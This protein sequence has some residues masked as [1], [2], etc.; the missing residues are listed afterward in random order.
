M[1]VKDVMQKDIIK[2]KKGTPLYQIIELF[3][4]FH[5][6]TLWVVDEEDKLLGIINLNDI[7][8]IFQPTIDK[9]VQDLLKTIRFIDNL[10]YQKELDIP[11]G[12]GYLF[13]ANDLM[14]EKFVSIDA[15]EKIEKAQSLLTL[16]KL[17]VLPVVKNNKLVGSI[18]Y[19]DIIYSRLKE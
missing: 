18:S 8:K 3:R 16:Y 4:N 19:I 15:D 6:T 5:L 10:N 13:I 14:E 2:I 17:D 12:A 7:L 11:P 1:L 9:S